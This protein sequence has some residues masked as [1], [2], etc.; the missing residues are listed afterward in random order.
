MNPAKRPQ[1][2]EGTTNVD[3]SLRRNNSVRQNTILVR[4]LR[5]EVLRVLLKPYPWTH[6]TIGGRSIRITKSGP[7][8]KAAKKRMTK[9]Q[10]FKTSAAERLE[11]YEAGAAGG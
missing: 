1:R 9:K 4:S 2:R 7:K 11:T 3:R 5:T 10:N 6:D 8:R